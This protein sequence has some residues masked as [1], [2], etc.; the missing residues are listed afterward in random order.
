VLEKEFKYFVENQVELF[1]QFPD[2]YIAIKEEKVI[3]V[4]DTEIDAY[5]ETQEKHSVDS[6]L[7]QFCSLATVVFIPNSTD[8]S[9]IA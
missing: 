2:Q 5:L 7:V 8:Y 6:F 3:G 1:K 9:K 4:F